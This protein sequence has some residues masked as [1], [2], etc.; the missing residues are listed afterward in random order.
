ML[1]SINQFQSR[2]KERSVR[3]KEE[4]RKVLKLDPMRFKQNL[5]ITDKLVSRSLSANMKKSYN[6]TVKKLKEF[7][8]KQ[9]DKKLNRRMKQYISF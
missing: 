5:N 9:N 3:I 6:N 1:V 7:I 4:R 2:K 8:I